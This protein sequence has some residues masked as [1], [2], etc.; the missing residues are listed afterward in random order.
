MNEAPGFEEWLIGFGAA[1]AMTVFACG[2]GFL[3]WRWWDAPLPG[4][5]K[6]EAVKT[7]YGLF[8][9]RWESDRVAFWRVTHEGRQQ[10]LTHFLGDHVPDRVLDACQMTS[11]VARLHIPTFVWMVRNRPEMFDRRL[12]AWM[13]SAASKHL[14]SDSWTYAGW[15]LRQEGWMFLSYVL[16]PAMIEHEGEWWVDGDTIWDEDQVGWVGFAVSP[17]GGKVAGFFA[18]VTGCAS[19]R[20]ADGRS[21]VKYPTGSQ[22]QVHDI[23]YGPTRVL[24]MA[25]DRI[26]GSER[27]ERVKAMVAEV[28]GDDVVETWSFEYSMT[29]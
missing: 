4:E 9:W 17:E 26:Q 11:E 21:L 16:M 13:I 2:L 1:M 15:G 14:L 22:F 8:E 12:E 5:E 23:V 19:T 24:D 3:M 6:F 27:F 28:F 25:A 10:T 18:E 7:P 20:T 29:H